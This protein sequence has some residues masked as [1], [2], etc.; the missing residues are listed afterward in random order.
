MWWQLRGQ[1]PFVG[2]QIPFIGRYVTFCEGVHK[3]SANSLIVSRFVGWIAEAKAPSGINS[4]LHEA[5][6]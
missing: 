3:I 2:R 4:P 6:N 1:I 5:L